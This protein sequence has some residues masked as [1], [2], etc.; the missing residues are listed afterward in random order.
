M[1]FDTASLRTWRWRGPP[2]G[3]I[4]TAL[5]HSQLSTTQRYLHWAENARQALAERAAS[6]AKSALLATSR[7]P[8]L[9]DAPRSEAS[10]ASPREPEMAFPHAFRR[11]AEARRGIRLYRDLR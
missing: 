8:E 2:A 1:G 4:M 3:E 10:I 6:V 5:G 9:A 7:A 11:K